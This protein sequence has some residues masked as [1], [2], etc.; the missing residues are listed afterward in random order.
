M[1]YE[2]FA[3][4]LCLYNFFFIKTHAHHVYISFVSFTLGSNGSQF[5][6]YSI[7]SWVTG[8]V[9]WR[10]AAYSIAQLETHRL[11]SLFLSLVSNSTSSHPSGGCGLVI[12]VYICLWSGSAYKH[13][14]YLVPDLEVI[15]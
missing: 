14:S 10:L 1:L 9:H 5:I 2:P 3:S 7:V 12:I 6:W 8:I 11:P 4:S 15:V 13:N